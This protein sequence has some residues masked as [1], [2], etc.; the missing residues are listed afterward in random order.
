M[1]PPPPEGGGGSFADPAPR[2][3]GQDLNPIYQQEGRARRARDVQP[4]EA[5]PELILKIKDIIPQL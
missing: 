2:R 4:Q 3:G 1:A 5:A